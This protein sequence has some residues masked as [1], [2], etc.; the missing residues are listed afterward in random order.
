MRVAKGNVARGDALPLQIG[1]LDRYV[2]VSQARPPDLFQVIQP[3]HQ[4]MLCFVEI[5]QGIE[6]TELARLR[7]LAVSDMEHGKTIIKIRNGGRHTTVHT[8]TGENDSTRLVR[9]PWSGVRGQLLNVPPP[10]LVAPTVSVAP[11]TPAGLGVPVGPTGLCD[12]ALWNHAPRPGG[13]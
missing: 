10:E 1:D 8:A 7:S 12:P 2:G 9:G 4:A 13:R 11:A 6:S 5:R 3:A